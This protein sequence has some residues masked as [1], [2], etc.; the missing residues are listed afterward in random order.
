MASYHLQLRDKPKG[1]A[2]EHY[3]YIARLE[4]YQHVRVK[5]QEVLEH[6]EPG[7]C[8]PSWAKD[9]ADFWKAA[10][11]HERANAKVYMEYELA[12]PNELTPEQRKTLVETFLNE[13]VASH[14]YPH[15]YAIHNVSTLR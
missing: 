2:L 4:K 1:Y 11:T 10:D 3:F 7:G 14:Q 12:L 9:P 6:I 5:S 15:S 8:M 13:H